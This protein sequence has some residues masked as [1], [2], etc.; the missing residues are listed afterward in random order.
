MATSSP[1]DAVTGDYGGRSF[2]KSGKAET[3][4]RLCMVI[5]VRH[6]GHG[7]SGKRGMQNGATSSQSFNAISFA[8]LHLLLRDMA[9]GPSLRYRILPHRLI[10]VDRLIDTV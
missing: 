9:R 7:P 2:V 3:C 6:R 1:A 4:L 10:E 5:S 8:L